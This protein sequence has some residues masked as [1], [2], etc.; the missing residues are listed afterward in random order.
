MIDWEADDAFNACVGGIAFAFVFVGGRVNSGQDERE[1]RFFE[2][3]GGTRRLFKAPL[4]SI[5]WPYDQ[6]QLS[7]F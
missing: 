1:E 6:S 4:E 2:G 3:T 7:T 5:T